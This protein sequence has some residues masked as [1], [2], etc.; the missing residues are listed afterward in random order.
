MS[1]T[2]ETILDLVCEQV[3]LDEDASKTLKARG[4]LD[5]LTAVDSLLMVDLVISLEE[6]FGI[7]FDPADI[8]PELVGDIS[9]LADYVDKAV[10]ES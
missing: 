4:R 1:E 8:D 9:R 7:R 5:E 2:R 10:R 3:G 6:R